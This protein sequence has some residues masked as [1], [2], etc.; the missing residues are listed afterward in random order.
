MPKP[1]IK[2]VSKTIPNRRTLLKAKPKPSLRHQILDAATTRFAEHGYGGCSMRDL[3]AE[4]DVTPTSI[5]HHFKDKEALYVE[6][7]NRRFAM[8]AEQLG[9]A[10]NQKASAEK[11]L[12]AFLESLVT[13][14]EGDR[15]YFRLV[16]LQL[17]ERSIEDVRQL[18]TMAFLPQYKSLQKLIRLGFPDLH[19]GRCAFNLYTLALGYAQFRSIRLAFPKDIEVGHGPREIAQLIFESVLKR[20]SMPP[21]SRASKSAKPKAG[22]AP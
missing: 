3:A 1:S 14:L 15:V 21:R 7:C 16:Q 11:Q 8:A 17:L 22:S 2:P 9:Q 13:L 12:L 20:N 4:L 10:F 19:P 18:S 6:V 5:Y